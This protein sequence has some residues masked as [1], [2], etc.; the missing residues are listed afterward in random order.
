MLRIRGGEYQQFPSKNVCLTVPKFYVG[1]ESFSVSIFSGTEKF[2]I[3]W[4]REYQDFPSKFFCLTGPKVFV[5]E[6]LWSFTNFGYR[7]ISCFRGLCQDFRFSVQVSVL[8][9]RKIS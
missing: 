8:Q 4:G 1:G 5:D 9:C 6:T 3:R 7:K 2:W